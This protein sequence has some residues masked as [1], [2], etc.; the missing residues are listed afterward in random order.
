MVEKMIEIDRSLFFF[1]NSGFTG[2]YMD[3]I[4]GLFTQLGTVR[5]IFPLMTLF[6]YFLDKERFRNN[7]YLL[8]SILFVEIFFGTII[9]DLVARPR[10][11]ADG[12]LSLNK[13]HIVYLNAHFPFFTDSGP[14]LKAQIQM[15]L[16]DTKGGSF[17]SGHAQ[18]IFGIATF[19]TTLLRRY[20][21]VIAAFAVAGALS[22]VYVGVHFPADVAVGGLIGIVIAMGVMNIGGSK[23][24][25]P[26]LETSR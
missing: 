13:I 9:K 1:L 19:L 12:V 16:G 3:I 10:P 18:V 11:M 4:M 26:T 20:R 6:L 23:V 25:F 17:P 5:V 7:F 15:G 24:R 8:T 2:P 22:R 21:Y 14:G